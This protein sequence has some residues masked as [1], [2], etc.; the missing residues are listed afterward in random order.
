MWMLLIRWTFIPGVRYTAFQI[1]IVSDSNNLNI[2]LRYIEFWYSMT[3]QYCLIYLN[4][5]C[6]YY[7]NFYGHTGLKACSSTLVNVKLLSKF[8]IDHLI[9]I[10]I[11]FGHF[12][13]L[14]IV[15]I[16][17]ILFKCVANSITF[18][19]LYLTYFYLV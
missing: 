15:L 8:F 12:E 14:N 5:I 4:V 10:W 9:L 6:Q 3:L 16:R 13:L 7:L 18:P 1:I 17:C 2:G 11:C 19:N